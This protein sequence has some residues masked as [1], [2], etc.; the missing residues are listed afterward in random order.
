MV[1]FG[2]ALLGICLL[3]GLILGQMLGSWMGLNANVA[4]RILPSY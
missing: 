3:T 4:G 2:V 1:I